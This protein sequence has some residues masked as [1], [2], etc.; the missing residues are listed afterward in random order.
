[1]PPSVPVK[2]LRPGRKHKSCWWLGAGHHTSKI[3]MVRVCWM[4]WFLLISKRWLKM[5]HNRCT[6]WHGLW[7]LQKITFLGGHADVGAVALL[8][9][10]RGVDGEAERTTRCDHLQCL[11][12]HLWQGGFVAAI[13]PSSCADGCTEAA[14][15][16]NH[17]WDGRICNGACVHACRIRWYVD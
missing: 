6:W 9:M 2:T 3:V 12:Q 10:V 11:D 8:V 13:N 16:D 15:W 5:R 4:T 7:W 17:V 14:W 1:M